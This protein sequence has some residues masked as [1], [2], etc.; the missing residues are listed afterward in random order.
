MSKP[1]AKPARTEGTVITILT[2]ALAARGNPATVGVVVPTTPWTSTS[3][4]F[5]QVASDGTPIVE[6][7]VLWRPTVRIVAWAFAT[8]AAQDLA[9]LCESLLLAYAGSETV[10]G[11]E[12]LTG[13]LPTKDLSTGAQLAMVTVRANLRGVVFA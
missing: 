4:P 11:F 9:Q 3:V 8:T 1:L 5:V 10:V 12:P 2:A 6:A 13:V 7:P